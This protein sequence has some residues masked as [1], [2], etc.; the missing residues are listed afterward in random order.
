[1]PAFLGNHKVEDYE[2]I[3]S[4]DLIDSAHLLMG[5]IDLDPASSVKANE[6]VNAKHFYTPKE[7]GLNDMDW[8]GNV[9]VFPPK[10]SYF[11]HR[12]S[13]RWKMTRGLSPTLTS[14]YSLW[15]RALKRKWLNGEIEQGVYFANAPDMFMYCQDIFDHPVCILRTRPCLMQHFVATGETKERTTCVSFVVF[16]QPHKNVTEST[17]SFIEIYGQKGRILV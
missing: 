15:W 7:D 5:G 8:F 10:H 17:E 16:L 3:T 1:M 11:W 12:E 2:W 6:Y 14:S 13:Q 4:R 9:Y